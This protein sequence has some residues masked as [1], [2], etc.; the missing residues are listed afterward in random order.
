LQH[1]YLEILLTLEM[2][3]SIARKNQIIEDVPIRAFATKQFEDSIVFDFFILDKRYCVFR[4]VFVS[5]FFN[6]F[7]FWSNRVIT[8][9]NIALFLAT[10]ENRFS[11]IQFKKIYNIF[12]HD[13]FARTHFEHFKQENESFIAMHNLLEQQ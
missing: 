7:L 10:F 4:F 6:N 1:Y 12:M 13:L 11:L 5:T 2:L 8:I 3:S 9:A